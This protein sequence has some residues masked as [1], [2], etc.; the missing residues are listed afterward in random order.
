[1]NSKILL[2]QPITKQILSFKLLVV[3]E[4][5][6]QLCDNNAVKDQVAK[7]LFSYTSMMVK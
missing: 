2:I 3:I 4:H 7:C 5:E 1:M 6:A